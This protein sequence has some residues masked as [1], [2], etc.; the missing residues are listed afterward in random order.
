MQDTS[1]RVRATDVWDVRRPGL[2]PRGGG[3]ARDVKMMGCC[4]RN[5][6]CGE[7]RACA[8]NGNQRRRKS[9]APLL[10]PNAIWYRLLRIGRI[11]QGAGWLA[12]ARAPIEREGV[13]PLSER[14]K[15][16]WPKMRC[17]AKMEWSCRRRMTASAG[18]VAAVILGISVLSGCVTRAA[19]PPALPYVSFP[20]Q[21]PERIPVSIRTSWPAVLAAAESAIPRCSE[22]AADQPCPETAGDDHFIVRQEAEWLPVDQRML[23]QQLGI[24]GAVWRRDPLTATVSGSHFSASLKLR[25]QARL[26]LVSGRQLA[27]C[28]FGEPPRELTVKLDGD[29]RFAPE[30]YLDPQFSV[31]IAPGSRCTATFLNFDITDALIGPMRKALQKEADDAADRIRKITNIRDQGAAIWATLNQPISI[32]DRIWFSPNLADAHIR[33]PQLTPDERYVSLV[34]G[35]EATPKVQIGPRP[36]AFPTPLP[37]LSTGDVSP[38]FDLKVRGLIPYAKAATILRQHLLAAVGST[39]VRGIRIAGVTVSG[40]GRNLVVALGVRGLLSGTLYIFGIPRFKAAGGN[41]IGGELSLADAQFTY[42]TRSLFTRLGL[43]LFRRRIEHAIEEAAWWDVSPELQAAFSQLGSGL[44]RDLTPQARL[45]GRLSE[46]GPGEVRVGAEGI[47]AW[48][49][50]G[51]SVE[52]VVTPFN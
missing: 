4:C 51:G 6:R 15:S 7:W 20:A 34:I 47:E 16:V 42:E 43:S 17:A 11:V 23:G 50:L 21:T 13:A 38:E 44:N 19:L 26:G 3:C 27:S 2:L 5:V 9:S 45:S 22:G 18:T 41:T 28:G 31:D 36:T 25:Y 30:W 14:E 32:G 40:R 35:L 49:R 33:L 48:Y 10:A 24:Q 1:T 8:T 46:F 12:F 37:P 39:G 52:V 29:L